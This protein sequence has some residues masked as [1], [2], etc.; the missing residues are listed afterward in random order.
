MIKWASCSYSC[1]AFER[2]ERGE[3]GEK[4]K[5]RERGRGKLEEA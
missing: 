5:R 3:G 2:E 1:G 4:K